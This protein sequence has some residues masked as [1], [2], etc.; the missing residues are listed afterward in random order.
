[1]N[2]SDDPRVP[3]AEK[4]TSLAFDRNRWA[5]ERTLMA[6]IRTSIAMVTFGFAVDRFVA[7]LSGQDSDASLGTGQH[8]YG[9]I[10]VI[11]GVVLLILAVVEHFL[12]LRRMNRDRGIK[13]S[14]FSLPM[15]AACL[16]LILGIATMFLIVASGDLHGSVGSSSGIADSFGFGTD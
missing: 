4:R 13:S 5:A 3:L 8:W 14:G 16:I 11:V 1:M 9:F 12:I 2:A 10:L 7:Y 6:W 15:F